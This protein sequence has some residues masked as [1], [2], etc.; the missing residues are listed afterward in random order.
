MYNQQSPWTLIV[1]AIVILSILFTIISGIKTNN[2]LETYRGDNTITTDVGEDI[3]NEKT[4]STQIY[5]NDTVAVSV[6]IPDDYNRV[7]KSGYDTFIHTPSSTS[8]Q[9]QIKEYDPTINNMNTTTASELI[10]NSGYTF[11]NF[12]KLSN[13]SYEIIYQKIDG[14]V[15]DYIEEVYWDR[16]HI[17]VLKFIVEDELYE[18]MSEQ[19]IYVAGS[20]SWIK[21]DP[22]PDDYVLYYSPDGNFEFC[23]PVDW[24]YSGS[25][26]TFYAV[27]PETNAQ[28]MVQYVYNEEPMDLSKLTATDMTG[29][30]NTGKSSFMLETFYTTFNKAEATASFISNNVKINDHYTL[31]S[32][33]N[34]LYFVTFEY[35][36]GTVSEEIIEHINT[37]FRIF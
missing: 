10:V 36:K 11:V 17:V 14:I 29:I 20:F 31:Y 19:L 22:I 35:E 24:N 3:P 23:I 4:F 21:E 6:E 8:I 12:T 32:A 25:G 27:N 1:G 13:S 5:T 15:Y 18:R 2:T 37:L 34:Y 28:Y 7:V 16:E 30:I 33:G 26:N 9:I